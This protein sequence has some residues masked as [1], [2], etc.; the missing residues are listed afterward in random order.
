MSLP[1][2]DK[3]A[4][5]SVD[6]GWAVPRGFTDRKSVQKPF[7]D[8]LYQVLKSVVRTKSSSSLPSL[9]RRMLAALSASS[10]PKGLGSL[11]MVSTGVS[12]FVSP[13]LTLR[14]HIQ[15]G[16]QECS[17][18]LQ[19]PTIRHPAEATLP[20]LKHEQQT[21]P[22]HSGPKATLLALWP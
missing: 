18:L 9:V 14:T 15:W 5:H 16:S 13:F 10:N 21:P 6:T 3:T 8:T 19:G 17:L 22:S 7:H 2:R 12:L 20:Q 1:V 4:G 11:I